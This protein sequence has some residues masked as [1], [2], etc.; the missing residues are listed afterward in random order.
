MNK[1]EKLAEIEGMSIED[2]CSQATF[3][4]IAKGIC[5]NPECEYTCEVEPDQ[6]EGYC[7]HCGTCTVTSAAVLAGII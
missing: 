2:L 1:L 5:S 4:G 7:E 6:R 3:D